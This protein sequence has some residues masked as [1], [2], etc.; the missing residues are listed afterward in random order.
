LA[1]RW[2]KDIDAEA[3]A[4][5]RRREQHSLPL[6]DTDE[7][8]SP[9]VFVARVIGV[10]NVVAG[11]RFQPPTFARRLRRVKTNDFVGAA[12]FKLARK[13]SPLP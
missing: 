11:Y 10:A 9:R 4:H 12:K 1:W 13:N 7:D 5:L 6:Q 3:T 2:L 8:A